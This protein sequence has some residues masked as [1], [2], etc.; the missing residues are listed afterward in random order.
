MA[1]ND[2]VRAR[3]DNWARWLTQRESGALGF[4]KANILARNRASSASTD[5][6]PVNDI[7]AQQTQAAVE[8]LRVSEPGLWFV[9]MCRYIGDPTV[10][11]RRRQ[12]MGQL[13]LADRLGV[14]DRTVRNY[15]AMAERAIDS[16]LAATP[17]G[18]LRNSGRW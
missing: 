9:V 15:E 2:W 5:N 6:I 10:P 12:P 3:L 18:V 17:K 13:E 1:R 4:P 14:G 16:A 7:E 8:G 11:P